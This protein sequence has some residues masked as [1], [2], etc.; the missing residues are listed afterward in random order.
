MAASPGQLTQALLELKKQLPLLEL[1][2]A[3]DTSDRLL[4]Q[5]REGV[6]EVVVGRMTNEAGSDCRFCPI[7]DEQLAFIV[8]EEHPLLSL[9][10]PGLQALQGAWLG[11]AARPAAPCAP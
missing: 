4:A 8:R 3:V 5:L 6:L 1:E 9:Q 11:D 7:D 10:R 2:V